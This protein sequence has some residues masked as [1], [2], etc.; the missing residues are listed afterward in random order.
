MVQFLLK[1]LW[2]LRILAVYHDFSSLLYWLQ[3]CWQ[4]N[5]I[6]VMRRS[7]SRK[8]WNGRT[9]YLLLRNPGCSRSLPLSFTSASPRRPITP[10]TC[11]SIVC[12]VWIEFYHMDHGFVSLPS[13][14]HPYWIWPCIKHRKR[15]SNFIFFSFDGL[16]PS[17]CTILANVQSYSELLH[18]KRYFCKRRCGYRMR[19]SDLL[20]C[21]SQRS[22]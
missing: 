10:H 14:G 13:S 9:F 2:K 3:N 15:S 11:L 6:H 22:T 19:V 17:F 1:F 7:R 8:F 16:C 5:F 20:S 12:S 21:L 18:F 4:P